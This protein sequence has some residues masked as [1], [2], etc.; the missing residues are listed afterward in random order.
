MIWYDWNEL[1]RSHGDRIHCQE[2]K[3]L[4]IMIENWCIAATWRGIRIIQPICWCLARYRFIWYGSH[5]F[6]HD[7]MHLQ[8]RMW[9][10][11][12]K[13]TGESKHDAGGEK[14]FAL[15]V[16]L[17]C[18]VWLHGLTLIDWLVGWLVHWR[19]D[20][21]IYSSIHSLHAG[22][23]DCSWVTSDPHTYNMRTVISFIIVVT[24]SLFL[25]INRAGSPF[26]FW[27]PAAHTYHIAVPHHGKWGAFLG[28]PFQRW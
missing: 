27:A 22:F 12:C 4:I 11:S 8:T 28:G 3:Y 13:P 1:Q 6:K 10:H 7:L 2:S 24:V 17:Q 14:W 25:S 5:H 23:I 15:A 9:I 21:F 16:C 20:S 18:E 19:T 26:A